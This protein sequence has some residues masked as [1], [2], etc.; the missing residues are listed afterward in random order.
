MEE[1]AT[2]SLQSCRSRHQI[3]RGRGY[4]NQCLSPSPQHRRCGPFPSLPAGINTDDSDPLRAGIEACHSAPLSGSVGTPLLGGVAI[5]SSN[6]SGSSFSN[7]NN[8]GKPQETK[9]FK[10]CGA[11]TP[12]RFFMPH[13]PLCPCGEKHAVLWGM[14]NTPDLAPQTGSENRVAR[15]VE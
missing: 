3:P 10:E 11:A 1:R 9:E 15:N 2:L 13:P 7:P 5:V 8:S 14:K 6:F 4:P 12:P